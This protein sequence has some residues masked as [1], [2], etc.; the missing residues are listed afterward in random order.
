MTAVQKAI[1]RFS[2]K[3]VRLP[4]V[5]WILAASGGARAGTG[6]R[7]TPCAALRS[8]PGAGGRR[9]PLACGRHASG[10]A[11]WYGT[12]LA[13]AS[14]RRPHAGLIRGLISTAITAVRRAPPRSHAPAPPPPSGERRARGVAAAG[15]FPGAA[16][17][18]RDPRG[19]SGQRTPRGHP[20]RPAD[21]AGHGGTRRHLPR[22]AAASST[23][24]TGPQ[25]RPLCSEAAPAAPSSR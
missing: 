3:Q 18:S 15:T 4:S 21:T 7:L 6:R 23:P 22:A 12:G 17:A 5:G 8:G 1:G 20:L 14:D 19:T 9:A 24:P 10:P 11:R 16:A 13:R 25:S 2:R